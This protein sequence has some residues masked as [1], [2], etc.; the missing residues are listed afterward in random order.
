MLESTNMKVEV[1]EALLNEITGVFQPGNTK[2]TDDHT[3]W[4]FVPLPQ[5]GCEVLWEEIWEYDGDGRRWTAGENWRH[6]RL[7]RKNWVNPPTGWEWDGNW[8]V[9]A[10]G[11]VLTL[12]VGRYASLPGTPGGSTKFYDLAVWTEENEWGDRVVYIDNALVIS[13]GGSIDLMLR[14]RDT[15]EEFELNAGDEIAWSWEDI[16]R[17]K[18]IEV[19]IKGGSVWSGGVKPDVGVLPVRIRGEGGGTLRACGIVRSKG[20]GLAL[21]FSEESAFNALVRFDNRTQFPIWIR[22]ELDGIRRGADKLETGVS[23]VGWDEP[24]VGSD[25]IF[26]LSLGEFGGDESTIKFI[27]LK[28][29][30]SRRLSPHKITG[31]DV[32]ELQGLRI[33][34]FVSGEGIRRTLT[35]TLI[36]KIVSVGSEVGS[37]FRRQ[38]Q[39]VFGERGKIGNDSIAAIEDSLLK[40]SRGK[41]KSE[42]DAIAILKEESK[43]AESGDGV[44]Q[45]TLSVKMMTVSLIDSVPAEIAVATLKNLRSA[46]RRD[47]LGDKI[48]NTKVGFVQIDNH[49]PGSPY[50]VAVYSDNVEG[51]E[52]A[53]DVIVVIGDGGAQ[54]IKIV[55]IIDVTFCKGFALS[56]DLVFLVRLQLFYKLTK[57]R[58]GSEGVSAVELA[59]RFGLRKWVSGMLRN[60]L[61]DALLR[62]Q[63]AQISLDPVLLR[64]HLGS[65]GSSLLGILMPVYFNSLRA[66][67]P[68]VLGSMAAFGNPLAVVTGV[69][70]GFGTFIDSTGKG[71]RQSAM[72]LDPSHAAMGVIE[73][74]TSL[75]QNVIGGIAQSASSIT[76][77]IGNNLAAA[78]F[79]SKYK[80]KRGGGEAGEEDPTNLLEGIGRGGNGFWMGYWTDSRGR[81]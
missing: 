77:T 56:L 55:K 62:I 61:F 29:G 47:G 46:M 21:S 8:K 48:I 23:A 78:T 50:P 25:G 38:S 30:E 64:H 34:V 71:F 22:Q 27:T 65:S 18:I 36:Q 59:T 33:L 66:S 51:E 69:T 15:V 42:A 68:N 5:Q 4:D 81:S 57:S 53:A 13:N 70:R 44:F 9:C 37:L 28:V 63:G 7:P 54:G 2:L 10:A 67:L 73:G 52:D 35:A 1:A 11:S 24:S 49:S 79:D 32:P 40:L 14:Q 6:M 20:R 58:L 74:T 16:R 3:D 39:I 41:L 12:P 31:L 43:R 26:A 72:S 60:I 76:S 19:R 17:A 45:V 75:G 80:K